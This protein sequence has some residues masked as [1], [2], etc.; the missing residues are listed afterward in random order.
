MAEGSAVLGLVKPIRNA[1]NK[2]SGWLTLV[3][4]FATELAMWTKGPLAGDGL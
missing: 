2:G 4:R 3:L 1:S